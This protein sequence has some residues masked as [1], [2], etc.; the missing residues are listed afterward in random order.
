MF[1]EEASPSSKWKLFVS[2]YLMEAPLLNVYNDY[3][4]ASK[5]Y[6]NM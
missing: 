3:N 2:I 6:R 1:Y 5:K 4:D